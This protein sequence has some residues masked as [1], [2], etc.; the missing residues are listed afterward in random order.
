M[1]RTALILLLNPIGFRFDISQISENAFGGGC[2]FLKVVISLITVVP[3][4]D[5]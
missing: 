3:D 4:T 1:V 5:T 2:A